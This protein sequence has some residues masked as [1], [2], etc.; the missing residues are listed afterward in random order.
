VLEC[1]LKGI[2]QKLKVL[3]WFVVFEE[4]RKKPYGLGYKV[5]KIE[6]GARMQ[7]AQKYSFTHPRIK[8]QRRCL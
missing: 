6:V 5:V 7:V 8:L 1:Q 2:K 3:V 4:K